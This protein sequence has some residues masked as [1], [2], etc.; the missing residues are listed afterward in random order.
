MAIYGP[1]PWVNPMEKYQFFDFLNFSFLQ[2]RK[3]FS[4]SKTS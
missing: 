2:P 3:A 4:R 1:K